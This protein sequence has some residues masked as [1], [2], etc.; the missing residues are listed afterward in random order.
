M[1]RRRVRGV[2]RFFIELFA[3]LGIALRGVAQNRLRAGLSILGV[4]IGVATLTALLSITQGL[5]ASFARQLAQMGASTLYVSSRPWVMR[6]DWWRYRNRPNLKKSDVQALRER[7]TL[8]VAVSPVV[9]TQAEVRYQGEYATE[10]DVR[11]TTEQ[12]AETAN[13]KIDEGRFLSPID[14]EYDRPVAVIGAELKERLFKGTSPIGASLQV[15]GRRF[16]V[17]GTLK[18]QG[19]AFGRSLDSN[20]TVPLGLFSRVFG[21]KRDLVITASATPETLNQ[22]EQQVI[23]VLRRARALSAEQDDNFAVNRQS[24]IVKMFESD[25]AAIFGV[26]IAVGVIALVVGGIGVMNIMLVAVTER[27]REIGVRRALGARQRTILMQ[28]LIESSL[29][30]LSGGLCGTALG[31]GGAQVFSLTTPV[32]AVVTPL[33]IALLIGGIG[34]MNIMLVSVTERTAEIGIRRA[35]GARR[36]RILAQ[37]IVEA[38]LLTSV[39]GLLG[40]ALGAGVAALVRILVGLPTVVPLWAMV[41]ALVVSAGTGLLFGS[42]PAYRASRLDPVEAMRHE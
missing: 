5:S 37:F 32:S 39:G 17:I 9:T 40:L 13:L 24:A 14:V 35:L 18:S 12:Y 20:V 42:Y 34:V 4:M 21:S 30:T 33:A 16:V 2:K 15:A 7:A 23:E 31:L 38:I 6:G 25:T 19:K 36:R 28:F 27:T 8:L 26:G 1:A 11:G 10:V 29:V 41:W 3:A 22:A